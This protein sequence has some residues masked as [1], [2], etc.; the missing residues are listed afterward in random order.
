M[1]RHPRH[2]ALICRAGVH[3]PTRALASANHRALLIHN[4]LSNSLTTPIIHQMSAL[5]R[6][7]R[8][9]NGRTNSGHR[10]LVIG[11]R[12]M[13][14]HKHTLPSLRPTYN[15]PHPTSMVLF[16]IFLPTPQMPRPLPPRPHRPNARATKAKLALQLGNAHGKKPP[17]RNR[18][19]RFLELDQ[20]LIRP[21]Y[22]SPSSPRPTLRRCSTTP[23]KI[24]PRPVM[25]GTSSAV[26]LQPR[27]RKP[28]LNGRRYPKSG[29]TPTNSVILPADFARECFLPLFY[30]AWLNLF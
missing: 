9:C 15:I 20:C 10:H 11:F 22:P 3:A 27:A 21:Q 6:Y 30:I 18:V 19:P 23:K 12:Q 16:D 25:F 28:C 26:S 13:V 14:F 29:L 17:P 7:L 5:L 2:R 24:P 8:S 1:F 4:N